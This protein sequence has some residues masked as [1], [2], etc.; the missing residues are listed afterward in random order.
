V[1]IALLPSA[2]APSVGGVEVLT[3]RLAVSL[4]GAGHDVEV[5]TARSRGDD[6]PPVEV[7]GGVQVRRFAF[8]APRAHAGTL[9]RWPDRARQ[10]YADLYRCATRFAPDVLHV[11]CFSGNGVYATALSRLTGTPLVVTLQGETVMDDADLYDHSA[12]MRAALRAGLR[13]ASRVTGCSQFTVD[14][15]VARFGLDPAKAEVVFNGCD[16]DEAPSVPVRLPFERF[17]L[18]L[19]RF[20]PKKGFDLLVDGFARVA[21]SVPDTG[22]VLVG[23]GAA[24]EEVRRQVVRLGLAERVHFTGSL[25]RGEVA[26]VMAAAEVFVMPSRVE[27]FGIVALEAWRAGTPVVVTS[28]GGAREFVADGVSGLVVDPG[29]AMA[30]A[31]AL[32]RLLTSPEQRESMVRAGRARLPEF[33]WDRQRERYEAVYDRVT[34]RACAR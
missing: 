13:Q 10:A 31:G 9:L 16:P 2:Y 24:M 5:W 1:R 15:A 33:A 7:V 25:G 26:A 4:L 8:P 12:F 17:V 29:D 32:D 11:Q 3:H 34:A 28:R 22:L 18:G 27:P 23:A 20:V 6:L 21:P 14:D 30:V 19:G